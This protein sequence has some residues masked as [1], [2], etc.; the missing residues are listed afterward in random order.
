V[1]DNTG[2]GFISAVSQKVVRRYEKCLGFGGNCVE[3]Q[4]DVDGGAFNF[5][6]FLLDQSL[7]FTN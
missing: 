1:V 6:L 3:K 2:C 7:L 5:E 4:W